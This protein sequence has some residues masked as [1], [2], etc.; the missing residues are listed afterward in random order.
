MESAADLQLALVNRLKASGAL[1][2]PRVES[3][4][5]AVP[6][7]LFVTDVPLEEVYQDQA[8]VTKR[9]DSVSVSSSSQ[10]AI[11]AVMLQQLALLP[12]HRVLEIGAG[13]GYNAALMAHIVGEAGSVVTVDIDDDIVEAARQHLASTGFDRVAVIRG[14][15]GLGYAPGAPYDRIILT[16]RAWDIAPAWWD[17]LRLG[18]R[19]VL[20]L[21]LHGP[22]LQRAIAFDRL[23]DHLASSS[24]KP[25]GFMPLRGGFAGPTQQ[26]PLGTQGELR[27]VY[28]HA[29]SVDADAVYRWL[30]AGS[31]ADGTSVRATSV[32]V[33]GGLQLW[34]ALHDARFCA[35]HAETNMGDGALIPALYSVGRQMRST[36]GLLG[37][38]G[39][40]VLS[41]VADPSSRDVN[42]WS[43]DAPELELEVRSFGEDSVVTESLHRLVV[44][45]H[46]AGRPGSDRL[47]VRAYRRGAQ[48]A[49]Q[50]S[51]R[52]IEKKWTSLFLDLNQG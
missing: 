4:F 43:P 18:G 49:T 12:G 3:A 39:L 9:V 48:P 23:D 28:A 25:C 38:R 35:V 14:D 15:G 29:T 5:R 45:W 44:G 11:M 41:W 51:T 7:H 1:R 47:E 36:V 2:D 21:A 16:V 17:Q 31:T 24:V 22:E 46:A 32:A 34:L 50:A 6:R 10:P 52:V 37:E 27:L 19:L 30:A 40:A 8:I 20:P 26:V 13:T 33:A 42:R